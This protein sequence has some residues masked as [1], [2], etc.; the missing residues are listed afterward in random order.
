[1]ILCVSLAQKVNFPIALALIYGG[2]SGILAFAFVAFVVALGFLDARHQ[3]PRSTVIRF[4]LGATAGVSLMAYFVQLLVTL[5]DGSSRSSAIASVFRSG[6]T[7]LV[8]YAGVM[9]AA[10]L[11]S[12]VAAVSA[13]IRTSGVETLRNCAFGFSWLLFWLVAVVVLVGLLLQIQ[14]RSLGVFV[15]NFLMTVVGGLGP[16]AGAVVLLVVSLRDGL[17]SFQAGLPERTDND[18]FGF[19]GFKRATPPDLPERTVRATVVRLRKS[20]E[21]ATSSAN[22]NSTPTVDVGSELRKLKQWHEEGLISNDDYQ[23]KKDQLL[24]GG[25]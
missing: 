24:G 10:L 2:G 14:S 17:V 21:A 8:I 20:S 3:A 9:F 18:G 1:L 12:L 16:L 4:G 25:G 22:Q 23:R 6:D 5:A 13:A 15:L 11:A 19:V 7:V